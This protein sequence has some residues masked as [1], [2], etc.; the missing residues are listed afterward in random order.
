MLAPASVVFTPPSHPVD[1]S[2]PYLWWSYVPG[3][4]WR[5]PGGPGT[6]LRGRLDHPVTHMAWPDALACAEWAGRQIPTEAEWEYAARGGL[7]GT[8]FARGD[9]LNPGGRHMANT[10]QGGFPHENLQ[11]AG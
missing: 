9:E 7:P 5:H 2:D 6:S 10:W 1:L 3:A 4:N 8:E 11:L